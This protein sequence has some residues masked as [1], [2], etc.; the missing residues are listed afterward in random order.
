MPEE[1]R[2]FEATFKVA[3]PESLRLTLCITMRLDEWIL[4]RTSLKK[5]FPELAETV[6]RMVQ[7]AAFQWTAIT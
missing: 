4:L 3:D 2:R 6:R 5:H 7:Q 1:P